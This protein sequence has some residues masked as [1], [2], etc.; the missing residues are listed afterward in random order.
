MPAISIIMPVYNSEKYLRDAIDSI[1]EQSFSDFELLLIDDGSKDGC[2]TI[3]DEYSKKDARVITVH[4][5]NTGMCGARNRGI[6]MARGEYIAFS[7]N[8]DIFLPG[9]LEVNYRV[10]KEYNA[11]M[12]KYGRRTL[13][14][15]DGE[16]FNEHIR[17]FPF[18][19]L[20]KNDLPDEYVRCR[21]RD[22]LNAVWDGIYRKDILLKNTIRFDTRLRF[23]EEDTIFCMQFYMHMNRLVLN[24]GVFYQH[25]VRLGHSA[26][27]KFHVGAMDK[28]VICANADM[29]IYQYLDKKH[30]AEMMLNIMDRHVIPI[31]SIM[32]HTNS[33]W[34]YEQKKKYLKDLKK[35]VG[36]QLRLSPDNMQRLKEL[37]R[38]AWL[39]AHYFQKDQ[40][41]MLLFISR[42]YRFLTKFRRKKHVETA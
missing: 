10:A 4:Q 14:V 42:T 1:L 15:Q 35:N 30:D 33:D 26:S 28:H 34:T 32:Y 6:E 23:G 19:V 25:Y 29:E 11:D 12:V 20:E 22:I 16:F 36:F 41:G 2:G 24:E 13:H 5:E 38:R 18:Q 27:T 21:N 9:L 8:D 40:Y 31:L 3:C 37:S 7:D 39:T 17:Q